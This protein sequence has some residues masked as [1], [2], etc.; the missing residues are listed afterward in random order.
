[1]NIKA[2]NL[3]SNLFHFAKN[4]KDIF[5]SSRFW[6]GKGTE[7][8]PHRNFFLWKEEILG[9]QNWQMKAGL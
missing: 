2:I 1:M 6:K 3:S 7:C 8:L 9:K 4:E 5:I